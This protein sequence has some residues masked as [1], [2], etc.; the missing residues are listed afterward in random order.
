ME[1]KKC[2]RCKVERTLD[3]FKKR[4]SGYE[5]KK[6]VCTTCKKEMEAVWREKNREIY[7]AKQREF[8]KNNAERI[9]KQRKDNY[10]PIKSKARWLARKIEAKKC[11]FCDLIGERH[12]KDYSHPLD[13]VFLCRSHHKKVH[14]GS[15]VL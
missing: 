15:I 5:T 4:G 13:I 12:H 10:D 7:Q 11:I 3:N 8:Y 1:L 9:K 14:D 6:S 2:S